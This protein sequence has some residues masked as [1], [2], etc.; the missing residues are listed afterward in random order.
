MK[1]ALNNGESESLIFCHQVYGMNDKEFGR[2]IQ[3]II[4]RILL[5]NQLIV[6]NEKFL[7]FMAM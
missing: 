3:C 6:Q 4:N 5:V 7:R 2:I 1:Q